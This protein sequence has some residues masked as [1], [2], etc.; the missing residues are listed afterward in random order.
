M[1][2][3]ARKTSKAGVNLCFS[4][5]PPHFGTWQSRGPLLQ[6]GRQLVLASAGTEPRC[7]VQ[8]P[9]SPTDPM[10]HSTFRQPLSFSTLGLYSS[11]W[12]INEDCQQ[13]WFYWHFSHLFSTLYGQMLKLGQFNMKIRLID[14]LRAPTCRISCWP[15]LFS[16]W[17]KLYY[18]HQDSQST[19]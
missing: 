8:F 17:N 19:M 13:R 14:M 9:L 12:N 18:I 2:K 3:I 7:Q 1:H 15:E 6:D 5:N 11:A 16:I 4:W 10:A